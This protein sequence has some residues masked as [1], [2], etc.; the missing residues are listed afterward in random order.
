M[1]EIC[2]LLL[3]VMVMGCNGSHIDPG[4]VDNQSRQSMNS[5]A[6][7]TPL[8]SRFV[9]KDKFGQESDVFVAGDEIT[10][11]LHVVNVTAGEVSY[12]ATPPVNSFVVKQEADEIWSQHNGMMFMQA[13]TTGKIAPAEA[14]IFT[15]KWFGKDND[16][17]LLQS[18]RYQVFSNLVLFVNEQAVEAPSP[19]W[20]VIN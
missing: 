3:S 19:K 2:I 9:I 17:A 13:I 10:F 8:E 1:R 7:S 6:V 12:Q 20:V 18:G 15:A 16:D 11:E 14:L 5:G 4:Q